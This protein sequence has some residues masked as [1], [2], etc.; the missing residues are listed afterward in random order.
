MRSLY[1][2]C[3]AG[4]SA[5]MVLKALVDM[6]VDH[7]MKEEEPLADTQAMQHDHDI[8]HQDLEEDLHHHADA[9]EHEHSH[10]SLNQV[11][12]SHRSLQEVLEIVGEAP[13]SANAKEY[14]NNIYKVI[15]EAEAE[16]HGENPETVHFHEVGRMEAIMNIIGI[17]VYIDGLDI[18]QVVCSEIHDGHGTTICSHGIVPVPVPAVSAM[19]KKSELKF[20][21]EDIE[22]ELVTPTGLGVLEGLHAR[23]GEPAGHI[24]AAGT[25]YGGKDT[26]LGGLKVFLTEQ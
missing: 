15:A 21:Q 2:D 1:I 5:D 14:A 19:M 20:V 16:V 4:I 26:G 7:M 17:A 23:L 24:I 3:K 6:R 13:I 11:E 8:E 12:H 10:C 25:G 9:H 18:E 22:S